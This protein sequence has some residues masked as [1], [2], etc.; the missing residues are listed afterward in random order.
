MPL[1]CLPS[2]SGD[3]S[4]PEPGVAKETE[5]QTQ[6]LPNK[7]PLFLVSQ[8][9]SDKARVDRRAVGQDNGPLQTTDTSQGG[10]EPEKGSLGP[11][12]HPGKRL[13]R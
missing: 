11:P 2:F 3:G 9:L 8:L 7:I 10:P 5:Q 6:A 13:P 12:G 4:G 1:P